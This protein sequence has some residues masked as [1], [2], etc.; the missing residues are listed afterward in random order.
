MSRDEH[1]M[2]MAI[3]L[4]K[5]GDGMTN[6]NPLVGAVVVRNG[7]VLGRGYHKRAGLPH[8]EIKALI[9]SPQYIPKGT[10]LN[11]QLLNFQRNK[12][13]SGLVVDEYGDVLGLV[14]MADILEE[15]VG[16]F[17]TDPND[18]IADVQPQE[19][20]S[21]LVAGSANLRELVRTLQWELPTDG[22]KTLNGLIIEHLQ[23]LPESG[24]SLMIA[25]YPIDVIQIQDN[26][27]RTARIRPLERRAPA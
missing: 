5:K 4:A 23:S 1:Y 15:I 19:D 9:R 10:P 17:A 3:D 6:P 13:R 16:E 18:S 27:V 24:T 22:P 7:R 2:K 21:F 25:G 12:R 20:G 8:A 14:T 11:R 26:M